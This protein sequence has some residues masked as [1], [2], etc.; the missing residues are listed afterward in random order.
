MKKRILIL[1]FLGFCILG[2]S[3]NKESIYPNFIGQNLNSIQNNSDWKVLKKSSGDLNKDGFNDFALILESKD[4]VLLK[5]CPDCKLL[6]NKPRIIVV[7]LNQNGTEKTIIQN[8][9]FIALG[10][11]GGMLPYLE[12]ELSIEDGLL[13]IY[14]QFTR[15]NQSYTFEFDKNQMIIIKAES[16][17]V[18][19]AS[20]NFEN[21]KYEFKKGEIISETGNI[22]QEKVKT[23][24]I[25]FNIKPKSLSEFREMLEWK[26]AENKYL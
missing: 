13:T 4:S 23:E 12:P 15:S 24:I 18:H 10:D 19:S 17:G 3:Q 2:C 16:N 11:E 7:L 8:N 20:G 5:R 1:F 6:K 26:I 14:Y 9:D 22:S 25:K 21:D